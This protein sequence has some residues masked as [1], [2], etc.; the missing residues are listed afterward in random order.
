MTE[1]DTP[2]A[3]PQPVAPAPTPPPP[4]QSPAAPKKSGVKKILTYVAVLF[5]ILSVLMNVYLSMIIGAMSGG[6]MSESILSKGAED[7][8]IATYSINGTITGFTASEFARFYRV[9]RDTPAIKA[10]VVRVDSPG[11]TVAGSDEI[12]AMIR[13]IRE[14]LQKPVVISMGSAAAS[15]GYYVSAP[16]NMIYAEPTTMTA[17]IGVI[18][19]LPV[20]DGFLKE[21]GVNMVMIR[22]KQ[23]Q[24]YKAAVN[25]FEK[26]DP[27]ILLLRQG[28]LDEM[29]QRFI[30]IVKQGRGSKLKTKPLTV[31]VKDFDGKDVAREQIYPFNGQVMMADEAKAVGLVD[32]I[33]YVSDA[34]ETAAR[35][36]KI[37][38]PTV[39]EYTRPRGLLD[40]LLYGPTPNV[41]A[42]FDMKIL[43]QYLN[44]TPMMIWQGQ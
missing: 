24:R 13:R 8:V 26:P 4:W 20:V 11:G 38:K 42:G 9:V 22:S 30:D 44:S 29:H 21:H 27:E 40:R 3:A 14:G 34:I 10:V 33:G 28:L 25:Y 31:T 39:I 36:A 35:L 43:D 32:E 19:P 12:Y 16:A 18:M 7:Q 2:A 5:F 41:P 37:D 6:P 1:Q 15:G 17:S 23:S